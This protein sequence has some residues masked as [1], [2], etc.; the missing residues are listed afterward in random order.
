M[1]WAYD[2]KVCSGCFSPSEPCNQMNNLCI[3]CNSS[4]FPLDYVKIHINN[5]EEGSNT[6]QYVILNLTWSVEYIRSTLSNDL[7]QRL[8]ALSTSKKVTFLSLLL[9][10]ATCMW[11][12]YKLYGVGIPTSDIDHSA[13]RICCHSYSFI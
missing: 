9:I 13:P 8:I 4:I 11:G 7:L 3:F 2:Q 10:M 5:F 12:L 1:P 6:G